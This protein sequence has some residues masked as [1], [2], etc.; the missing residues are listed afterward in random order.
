MEDIN[1]TALVTVQAYR[2]IAE[3]ATKRGTL[4]QACCVRYSNEFL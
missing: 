4:I 2:N 3:D 1:S